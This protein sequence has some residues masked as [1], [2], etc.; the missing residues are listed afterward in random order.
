MLDPRHG[1]F[2]VR[3]DLVH[4]HRQDHFFGPESHGRYSVA[5]A[6][7]VDQQAVQEELTFVIQVL[8]R[9]GNFLPKA[10]RLVNTQAIPFMAVDGVGKRNVI[11]QG[12]T[13]FSGKYIVEQVEADGQQVRRLYFLDNPFVIQSEVILTSLAKDE[14]STTAISVDK[15]KAAFEYHKACKSMRFCGSRIVRDGIVRI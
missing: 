13:V 15:S 9:Q 7:K 11:A 14:I 3:R 5:H 8:A 2:Q 12:E 4:T 6:V 1:R 10:N